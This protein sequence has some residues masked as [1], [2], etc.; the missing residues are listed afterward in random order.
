MLNIIY[1]ATCQDRFIE[2][3][4]GAVDWLSMFPL[5]EE[6]QSEFTNFN[7]AIDALVM[8]GMEYL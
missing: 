6:I 8:G 3:K 2:D 5:T 7:G 1:I 4:D